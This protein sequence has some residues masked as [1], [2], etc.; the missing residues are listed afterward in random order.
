MTV[1]EYKNASCRRRIGY[2]IYRN[3]FILFILGPVFHFFFNVD[4]AYPMVG[5]SMHRRE[6]VQRGIAV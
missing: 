3:T 6:V 1:D 5:R 4:F 2:R